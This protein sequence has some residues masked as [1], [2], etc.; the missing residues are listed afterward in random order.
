MKPAVFL[1]RDGTIIQDVGYL[2]SLDR[3][4]FFPWTVDSIRA[5]NRAGLA[6]VVVTNQSAI[7]RGVIDEAFVGETH[8]R[9]SVFIEAGGARIDAY[10]YCPH[11]PEGSVDR[12]RRECTCRKPGRELV[13]RAAADLGLDLAQSTV[14]GDRWGDV[15]LGRAVGARALLVR[16][17]VGIDEERQPWPELAADAT[18]DNLAAAASWILERR[19]QATR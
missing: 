12:Y 1:D 19:T 5:F 10:Y 4:E 17:G 2:D 7:A 18:V 8:R 14:V 3:I 13:D 6:V 15:Q 9:I 11:H 16:T